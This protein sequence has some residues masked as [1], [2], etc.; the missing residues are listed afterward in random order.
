MQESLLK[1]RNQLNE[2]WDRLD[3]KQRIKLLAIAIF[4]FLSLGILFYIMNRPEY[5]VLYSDLSTKDAGEIVDVLSKELKTPYKLE[6]NGSTILVPKDKKDEIR[7]KLATKGLPKNGF[8]FSDAFDNTKLGTTDMELRKRYLYFLQSEIAQAIKTIEGVED[9]TVNIVVPDTQTFVLSEKDIPA[10]AAVLLKLSPGFKPTPEQVKGIIDFVSKSVEGLKPQNVTVIDQT[11]QILNSDLEVSGINVSQQYD[12]KKKIEQ[13]LQNSVQTLLEQIFG[14]GNVAVR[15]N[16][17]LD[18]NRET[19][20]S[21]EFSPVVDDKGIIRSYQ[22]LKEKAVNGS[23]G[24]VPGVTSNTQTTQ[25]PT[26]TNGGSES[27]KSNLIVNYEINEIRKELVKAQGNIKDLTV[28]VVV[29]S[30]SLDDDMK[31]RIKDLVSA[32]TGINTKLVTVD[33]FPFNTNLVDQMI[34]Q[35]EN[36]KKQKDFVNRMLVIGSVVGLSAATIGYLIIRRRRKLQPDVVKE[37]AVTEMME[38]PETL[39]LEKEI[40]IVDKSASRKQI[41]RFIEKK[42]DIVA[43]LLR[44]WLNEE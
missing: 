9:A 4:T 40:E 30:N 38:K 12:L 37:M 35:Q 22:E 2:F 31:Q 1:I 5:V 6:N 36:A 32:T 42:P 17:E 16:V 26:T 29:N 21:V 39:E 28:A 14:I 25:Y 24:G 18:F 43:Q 11:G 23:N 15:V 8:T 27:D 3:K 44:N 41:E 34:K 13:E 7:M 19:T 10:T 20:N 33:G